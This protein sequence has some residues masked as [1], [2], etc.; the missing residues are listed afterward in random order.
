LNVNHVLPPLRFSADACAVLI[1]A[2][3]CGIPVQ[4]NTFGQ[5][6]ASS[7]VTIAGC[8]A[9]TV[10]ETLAGLILCWL[11]NPRLP[12]IFGPRPMIT[13]L[14]TG[15]MAGGSGEQALLTA[16]CV[17][18]AN[19]LGLANSTIAGATDAK[20]PDAQAGYEKSLAVT[21]AAQSGAN[22]I[23]QSCGM[24][25]G[26]M[27]CSPE[28]YVI[29]NDMI[30]AVMQSLTRPE[31]STE[32]LGVSS[33]AEVVRG[34]GHFLGQ[35][36]TLLRMETDFLYPNIA[37]RRSPEDWEQSGSARLSDRARDNAR[38]ILGSHRPQ[39]VSNELDVKIREQ[40]GALLV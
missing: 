26:L 31:V 18:A 38:N 30:G 29:D 6:G 1:E 19:W 23:T 35:P 3:R 34:E 39:H 11:V 37:D 8:A 15:G 20:L 36:E 25:A 10:A 33:I 32:T 40:F 5:L 13:D 16:V 28:A 7:P 4:V 21:L 12:A 9:Q 17:Q 2:A 27:G 24:L 14:R 22:L